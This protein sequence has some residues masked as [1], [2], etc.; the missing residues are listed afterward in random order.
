M[1]VYII[2]YKLNMRFKYFPIKPIFPRTANKKYDAVGCM[3][4]DNTATQSS[5]GL[6]FH[7][8]FLLGVTGLLFIF[9]DPIK[10]TDSDENKVEK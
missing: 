6:K 5:L 4:G 9:G 2:I 7:F 3:C 8:L 1:I 10:Q